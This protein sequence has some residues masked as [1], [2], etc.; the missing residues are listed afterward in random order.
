MSVRPPTYTGQF[1]PSRAVDGPVPLTPPQ[2]QTARIHADLAA[3]VDSVLFAAS[4]PANGYNRA[5][6]EFMAGLA[7]G[8]IDL[9]GLIGGVVIDGESEFF[10]KKL[11][12]TAEP[13]RKSVV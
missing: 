12:R 2:A 4:I 9:S 3:G 13:D 10:T 5:L 8:D 6:S 1:E 11:G 7:G